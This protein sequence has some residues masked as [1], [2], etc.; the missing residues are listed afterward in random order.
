M[1]FK[2]CIAIQL[3][4]TL[5]IGYKFSDP[6]I[7]FLKAFGYVYHSKQFGGPF[8]KGLPSVSASVRKLLYCTLCITTFSDTHSLLLYGS[9]P[10]K[11]I[12]F[13][14]YEVDHKIRA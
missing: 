12:K 3:E 6:L 2:L 1:P 5:C 10:I 9:L 13:D 11:E 8:Y 14:E 7:Y 4:V